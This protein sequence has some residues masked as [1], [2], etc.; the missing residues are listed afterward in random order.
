VKGTRGNI[1]HIVVAGSGV[2]VIDAKSWTGL[3]EH[4]NV[5][6]WLRPDF[7]LFVDRRDQTKLARG[8]TWQVAAVQKV[9]AG[10][11]VPVFAALC[12][13]DAEWRLFAKPFQHDGVWV[14]WPRKL[15]ELISEPGPLADADILAVAECLMAGMPAK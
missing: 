8:L 3:V 11:D 5:G 13:T 12:F 4:R 2:W 14:T 7:R 9:L 1:D 6:G 10:R 15:V